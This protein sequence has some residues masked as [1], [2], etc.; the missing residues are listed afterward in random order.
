M[1]HV[2]NSVVQHSAE[3]NEIQKPQHVQEGGRELPYLCD[4]GPAAAPPGESRGEGTT[5]LPFWCMAFK[6]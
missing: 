3:I 6:I 5:V 2:G 1:K 4:P